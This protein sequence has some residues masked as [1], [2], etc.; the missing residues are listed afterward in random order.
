MGLYGKLKSHT[1]SQDEIA[2]VPI[3]LKKTAFPILYTTVCIHTVIQ[4]GYFL[5][6]HGGNPLEPKPYMG[7]LCTTHLDDHWFPPWAYWFPHHL[8]LGPPWGKNPPSSDIGAPMGSPMGP[9]GDPHGAPWGTQW[10]PFSPMGTNIFSYPILKGKYPTQ[11]IV[12]FYVGHCGPLLC[13]YKV[14]HSWRQR[15]HSYVG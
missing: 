13:S 9:H 7:A 6:P 12:N 15:V 11:K 8:R 10:G 4:Y 3:M 2:D 1:H 14:W 5:V